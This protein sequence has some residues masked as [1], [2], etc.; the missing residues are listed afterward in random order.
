MNL[1]LKKKF[2]DSDALFV[3]V[4]LID[5]ESELDSLVGD[6]P[7]VDEQRRT[8]LMRIRRLE[9]APYLQL[10]VILE[11]KL[12]G[13]LDPKDVVSA[14]RAISL[15]Y[16]DQSIPCDH[17]GYYSVDMVLRLYVE[18]ARAKNLDERGVHKYPLSNRWYEDISEYLDSKHAA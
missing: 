5:R 16:F 4:A 7:E 14:S 9:E 2:R 15:R 17:D 1:A 6:S 11:E 10:K 3:D 12:Q 8:I 18:E 13:V